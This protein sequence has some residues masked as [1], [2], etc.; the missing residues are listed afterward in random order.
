[1]DAEW[2]KLAVTQK[3]WDLFSVMEKDDVI[4]NATDKKKKVYFG[5]LMD[6]CHEKHSELEAHL[7]K[8]KGRV[9]FRGD[10]VRDETGFYAVFSEQGTSA[11]H[12]SGAKFVDAIARMPG[13][14][15][16][17]SDA[18]GAYTQCPLSD[19]AFLL[20]DSG[21]LETWIS[22]PPSR[23]P[24]HWS[25]YRNPVCRLTL[26]LYGHPLAGLLWE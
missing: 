15:G 20:E 2:H 24:A 10:Q 16:G 14:S 4:Q 25:K 12:Q 13:C 9:V 19:A 11:S 5:S 7:R 26:N 21:D 18:V 6:S 22:L 3:A 17:D 8:Y 1:V 23:R